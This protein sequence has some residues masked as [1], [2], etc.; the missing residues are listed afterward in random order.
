MKKSIIALIVCSVFCVF[1]VGRSAFAQVNISIDASDLGPKVS[2]TLY[3]I[4]YEDINHA[5]DGGLY[6]ELIRNRS[7][8]DGSMQQQR[9]RGFGGPERRQREPRKLNAI[10]AWSEVGNCSMKLVTTDLLN[11]AQNNALNVTIQGA[12]DGV[13]NEGFWGINAV[14]GQTYKLSFWAK[15]ESGYKGNLTAVLRMDNGF[16]CS[17]AV[18]IPVKLKAKWQKFTAEIRIENNA[19][20]SS[21]ELTAD[22]PGTLQLDMVSLF[23]PTYKNRENGMRRDLAE[24]LEAMHPQFMRFPGGCFVE[25][26]GSPDNA[27]RWAR[28]IGPIETRPGHLNV[29]WGYRTSDGIGFHEYLQLAEDLGAKPLFVVNVGIWHGGCD[30]YDQ[31][32]PWIDE[33]LGALEYANGDVTTKYGKMRAENGHP[34]PF[35]LEYIEIGNENYNFHMDNNSDQSD[36]YPERYIQFYN[37]I[38]AKYPNVTCIGNVESWSTDTPSWR[39]SYPVDMVD[40]HYYRNPSWFA[41]RFH[42]YDTYPRDSHKIY[43][44]EYAVTSQ[45]GDIGNLNAA[46]GEAVYMMGM[47]NNSDV[48]SMASYAPIF[49]NE[50]DARWRPD[51]I[52]FN[53]WQS[54][55]TPSYYVQQL[56]PNNI[57]T[58]VVNT[59]YQYTLPEEKHAVD[60]TPVHVGLATWAT[61]VHYKDAQ[62]IID[63][64]AYPL[65]FAD[66]KVDEGRW[67][68]VDGEYSQTSLQAQPAMSHSPFDIKAKKYTFKVKAMKTDGDEGFMAVVGYKDAKT[69]QWYNVGGWSNSQNNIEQ[70]QGGG[71]MTIGKDHRFKVENGRW[72]E[73]TIEVDGDKLHCSVDGADEQDAKLQDSMMNGVYVST[74]LDEPS[75]DMIVKVV[76]VGAG[77]VPGEINLKNYNAHGATLTR[78]SSADGNDEN[79]L[80]NPQNIVPRTG[81]VNLAGSI[82]TF[83]VPAYSVNIIRFRSK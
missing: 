6:A 51:M 45:F 17:E 22:K 73:L 50:N 10:D 18:K 70:T 37:A 5:A 77:T 60:D 21:F 67:Q 57:G 43:V 47:E 48:V 30:P 75:G 28:T 78:L 35:N 20:K 44:G 76:N 34:E 83:E 74:S 58:R 49:V 14:A 26:Q 4:F 69:Y 1:N 9:R 41:K 13:R 38:K 39:N 79:T 27:F 16:T 15:A 31:I 23:P 36:H 61:E 11:D 68:L 80:Q 29:N 66:W 54:M 46:L 3:G 24:M 52:R 25:G 56:F 53:S 42:K 7:F 64:T 8:E 2:P 33:C 81:T 32:Q 55:G 12:G 72:Y 59:K 40:E 63:D 19:P 65:D 82:A 62:I 71:K